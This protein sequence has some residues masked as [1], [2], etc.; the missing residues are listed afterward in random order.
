MG[1]HV[2]DL[3]C[4]QSWQQRSAHRV[5]CGL[6][7]CDLDSRTE[8][9]V[10]LLRPCAAHSM[11]SVTSGVCRGVFICF[12]CIH[13]PS[14][15]ATFFT[16]QRL[17]Y[18]L[19]ICMHAAVSSTA[20]FLTAQSIAL[21]SLYLSIPALPLYIVAASNWHYGT[22]PHMQHIHIHKYVVVLQSTVC[23]AVWLF[24]TA[25]QQISPYRGPLLRQHLSPALFFLASSPKHQKLTS[26]FKH[27]ISRG[28]HTKIAAQ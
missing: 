16:A 7:G 2:S 18:L 9:N 14:S 25:R 13:S 15:T 6:A 1:H 3:L 19:C 24:D 20:T 10:V 5:C 21:H 12:T 28:V 8:L 22:V 27:S 4:F 17:L 23:G 26:L 11:S